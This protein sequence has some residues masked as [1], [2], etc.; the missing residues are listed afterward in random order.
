MERENRLMQCGDVAHATCRTA[1]FGLEPG[2]P[3]CVIHAIS[4][5]ACTPRATPNLEGR[6][7]KCSLGCGSIQPSGL[8]LAFFE[9]LGPG[10]PAS[11][12]NCKKCGYFDTA[13]VRKEGQPPNRHVCLSF[14]PHGPYEFDKYYCGCRGWD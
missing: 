11:R 10:S 6:Q 13:H 14:A 1:H 7:A 4:E 12:Q 8:N 5:A 9:Y 2:H 3:S